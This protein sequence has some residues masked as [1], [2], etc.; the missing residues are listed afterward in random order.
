MGGKLTVRGNNKNY[1]GHSTYI[2][3]VLVSLLFPCERWKA[4]V[5]WMAPHLAVIPAGA[6]SSVQGK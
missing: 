1:L 3:T 2:Y 4:Q 6:V 5:F